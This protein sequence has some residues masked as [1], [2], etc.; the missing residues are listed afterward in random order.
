MV[1][2]LLCA[3]LYLLNLQLL[4][5]ILYDVVASAQPVLTEL[6]EECMHYQALCVKQSC[7]LHLSYGINNP[8]RLRICE[9]ILIAINLCRHG[10][11]IATFHL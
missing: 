10:L 11:W 7:Q 1:C 2:R 8:T 9:V 6:N 4:Y 3:N 5:D